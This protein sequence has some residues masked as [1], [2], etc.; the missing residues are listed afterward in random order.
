LKVAGFDS[1]EDHM[2]H[3]QRCEKDKESDCLL[4]RAL[5]GDREALDKL[6]ASYRP[7]LYR[8]ALRILGN[9]QD[10]ED[11]LQEALFHAACRLH[12]FEGR[13]QF[14]TWLIRI[15]INT[16][17]MARRSSRSHREAPLENWLSNDERQAPL[18]IADPRPDPEQVCSSSEIAASVNEQFNLLPPALRSAF[19]LRHIEGLTCLEAGRSL[20]ISVSAMKSRVRRARQRL[21]ANLIY[22]SRGSVYKTECEVL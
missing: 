19:R 6:L 21:A 17:L 9:P 12:Q 7:R 3:N 1:S 10:A 18:E 2:N 20:G 8:Q 4:K 13:S 22:A 5:E 11:A 15:V 14:S 16:A